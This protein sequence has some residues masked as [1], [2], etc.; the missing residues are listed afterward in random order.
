MKKI[1][2]SFFLFWLLSASLGAQPL[3]V[4]NKKTIATST[5]NFAVHVAKGQKYGKTQ[6]L[7]KD[8][9]G[10]YFAIER[11]Q[12]QVQEALKQTTSVQELHWSDLSKPLYLATELIQGSLQPGHARPGLE[13][14]FVVEHPLLD[15]HPFQTY[16]DLFIADGASPLPASLSAFQVAQQSARNLSTGF[17]RLAAE[18][19]AYGAVAFQYLSEDLLLKAVEMNELL[20]QPGHF[21]MT[22]AQRLRLQSYAEEYLLLSGELLERADQLLLDLGQV[23]A[24]QAI[25]DQTHFQLERAAAAQT[26]LFTY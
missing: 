8:I 20:K 25:A 26:P 4:I 12:R 3:M 11:L 22:E 9:H 17:Q 16:L 14:D 5:E 6:E 23:S 15:E 24:L 10:Q 13:I 7:T 21:S 18:R 19:K 2:P 1:L